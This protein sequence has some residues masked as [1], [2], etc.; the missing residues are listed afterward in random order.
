MR[1]DSAAANHVPDFQRAP[2]RSFCN[3]LSGSLYELQSDRRTAGQA[4]HGTGRRE[5]LQWKNV[6]SIGTANS[7]KS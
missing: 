4:E 3:M 7:F 5:D 2:L 1:T 6:K